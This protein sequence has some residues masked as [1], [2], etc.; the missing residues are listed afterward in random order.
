MLIDR[1][2]FFRR[3]FRNWLKFLNAKYAKFFFEFVENI[4]VRKGV[5]LSKENIALA[6]RSALANGKYTER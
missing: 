4:L 6:E 2:N 3:F 1:L 5:S